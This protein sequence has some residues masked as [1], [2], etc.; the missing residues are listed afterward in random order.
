MNTETETVDRQYDVI[1][2]G[3][4]GFTGKLVV[5][6][7]LEQYGKDIAWAIAGRNRQKL[8]QALQELSASD[9]A[10]DILI[11]D[12]HDAE[13]MAV[14]AQATRVVLTT[15]GPYALYGDM[16]VDA[17]AEHGTHYC[18]LAGEV[19]WMRRVIDRNQ[20]TAEQSGARIV[21]SCGFDSIPSDL[22]VQFLQ[23]Q[24]MER[25]GEPCKRVELIVRA[26]RGGG[27]GG[28]IAS[29]MN[30]MREARNDRDVAQI[31][32]QPYSLNPEGERD[33]PDGRDQRSSRWNDLGKVWTAPFIMGAINMR[34]VRRSNALLNFPWGKDFRYNESFS[35]GSGTSGWLKAKSITA[36]LGAFILAGS[37]DLSR[38]LII[39]TFLPAPGEGP[40]K[41]KRENG[42]FKM[43][44]IGELADGTTLRATVTGD[45]DP[46]YGSTSKMLSES[47]VCLAK[48]DLESGGGCWTPASAMGPVLRE[49][50]IANAGL[51]FEIE[52]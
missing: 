44:L 9:K 16:L 5:E 39:E 10:P 32:A 4:S 48:N 7:F 43:L 20:S 13:S 21:H 17:C 18:D 23:E 29:G 6:Y 8:E 27:S 19:Q 12:S 36:G 22:G 51:T 34:V 50:L 35:T 40:G 31:L 2:W 25:Y 42:F 38:K 24:A 30:S 47:A 49:R 26:M 45:R 11:A 41:E 52:G 14:L 33:G 1:V 3:A 28:T 46:G 15:V 37:F